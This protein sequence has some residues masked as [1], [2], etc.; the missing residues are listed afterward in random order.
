[1]KATT[2]AAEAVA[3]AAAARTAGRDATE[4]AASATREAALQRDEVSR[5]KAELKRSR[6]ACAEKVKDK[7]KMPYLVPGSWY[8]VWFLWVF[9]FQ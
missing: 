6:V 8:G 2:E 3:A 1:M 9:L 4:K 5:L 7:N